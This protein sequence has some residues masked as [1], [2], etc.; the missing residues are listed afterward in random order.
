MGFP[1]TYEKLTHRSRL[2]RESFMIVS[3]VF[4]LR[5]WN[6][7]IVLHLLIISSVLHLTNLGSK[8]I[9]LKGCWWDVHRFS[10]KKH[11][12]NLQ[13]QCLKDSQTPTRSGELVKRNKTFIWDTL[14]INSYYIVYA[15][16]IYIY[17][18]NLWMSNVH[19]CPLCSNHFFIVV[20]WSLESSKYFLR[21]Y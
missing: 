3:C 6:N 5:T 9:S 13:H 11:V 14:L 15:M 10:T 19:P 7:F 18:W 4:F 16:H 8:M 21:T 17:T 20:P 1:R 2:V 12:M